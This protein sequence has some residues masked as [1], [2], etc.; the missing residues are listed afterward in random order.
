MCLT[1]VIGMRQ[2]N[3]KPRPGLHNTSER[4]D[5]AAYI[6]IQEICKKGSTVIEPLCMY[7]QH[8]LNSLNL[9]SGLFNIMPRKPGT[10]DMRVY[11]RVIYP[12]IYRQMMTKQQRDTHQRCKDKTQ[13]IVKWLTNF[14][15]NKEKT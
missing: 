10:E 12:L 5:R 9:L 11:E 8:Y 6:Q 13:R 4:R 7:L 1:H 15:K 3:E 14:I 2:R